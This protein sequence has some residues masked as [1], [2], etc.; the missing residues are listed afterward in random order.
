MAHSDVI[1]GS[2]DSPGWA[3]CGNGGKYGAF[4]TDQL[5]ACK[6]GMYILYIMMACKNLHVHIQRPLN[7]S[8]EQKITTCK[9]DTQYR[10]SHNICQILGKW[11][12]G[13]VGKD[14]YG[15]T[16]GTTLR[17]SVTRVIC[18]IEKETFEIKCD[19]TV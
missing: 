5:G 4:L 6:A 14:M 15:S 1:G 16:E 10:Y 9:I 7:D 13:E 17:L 3:T 2:Q 18:N 12:D 11:R 19:V 8:E